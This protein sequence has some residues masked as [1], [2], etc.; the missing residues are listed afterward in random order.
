MPKRARVI[1]SKTIFHGRVVDLKVEQVIEPGGVQT[2][3]EVVCHPGSVVVVT[4]A[5]SETRKIEQKHSVAEAISSLYGMVV[6]ATA[7]EDRS[8]RT[9]A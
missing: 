5:T 4:Y 7:F 3:R 8:R 2:T 1:K 6:P 9:R